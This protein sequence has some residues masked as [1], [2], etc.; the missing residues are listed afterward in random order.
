VTAPDFSALE[1]QLRLAKAE[2]NAAMEQAV[3]DLSRYRRDNEPTEQERRALQEAALRGDL[4]DDMR[5]LARKVDRGQDNWD[6]IFSGESPNA[7]LLRGHLDRMLTAHRGAIIQA[8]EEDEDFDPYPPEL[9][10][11][12]R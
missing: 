6:A 2:L 12:P 8:I 9:D 10:D 5:E 4:G 11:P 1:R 3:R 7:E